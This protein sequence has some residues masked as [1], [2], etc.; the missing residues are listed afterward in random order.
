MGG[1][2][3]AE[4]V[5]HDAVELLSLWEGRGGQSQ[6][7]W[8]GEA[9]QCGSEEVPGAWKVGWVVRYLGSEW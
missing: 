9:A 7:W 5:T 6:W 3:K 8:W 4:G 2:G 1:V